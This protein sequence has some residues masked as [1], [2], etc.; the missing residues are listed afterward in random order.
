M[1]GPMSSREE[2]EDALRARPDDAT[3]AVY[4]DLLQAQGDPRGE[5]IA[6]DL[7]PPELSSASIETR[8]AQLLAAW[9]GDE[10]E[11][12]WDRAAGVWLAGDPEGTHATFACGF[13]EV[14]IEEDAGAAWLAHVLAGR[15]GPYL[16]RVAVRG[17]SELLGEVLAHLVARSRPWL[18]HLAI[19]RAHPGSLLVG[20][21]FGE[22]L[23]AALPNLELLELAGERIF[24]R[25]VHEN[26]RELAITG[27]D[28]IELVDGPPLPALHT[29]DFA[30]AGERPAPSALFTP[31]RV[32]ALRRLRCAR[33]EPGGLRLFEALGTLAVAPQ[34]THLELPSLRTPDDRA[35][36]QAAI[37]RMPMLREVAIARAYAC[38]G[39]VG[40]LRHPWA[41][42]TV[43]EPVA[44]PPR[45]VFEGRQ[46]EIDGY[47]VD[48]VELVDVLEVQHA[49]LP[50]AQRAIWH[51]LWS[52]I[53]VTDPR[54]HAFSAQDLADA[55]GALALPSALATFHWHL[56]QRLA[57]GG[58]LAIVGWA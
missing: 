25:F 29:I 3:L 11:V 26:L 31:A 48:P 43:P 56:R 24:A 13:V 30:F 36:V 32:P 27:C 22:R 45:E 15:G 8:R 12:H 37:D 10:L 49:E 7:Q 47:P 20:E 17:R 23:A 21:A 50:E 9:L 5:L 40:E 4:A 14:V 34:L 2:L 46:L 53:D 44:W 1:P 18:Q 35:L 51:R 55:L 58:Y 6:L 19:A 39:P 57:R 33:A 38:H 16:R 42:V 28:A 54:E 52:M 41:R